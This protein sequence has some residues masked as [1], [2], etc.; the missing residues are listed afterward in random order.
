[1]KKLVA[2][3]GFIVLPLF[4][5]C[6]TGTIKGI[7]KLQLDMSL[8]EVRAIFPKSLQ[9]QNTESKVK[10]IYKINTYTPIKGTTLKGLH[11]YF[12]NDTLYS[13]Y[14]D[15]VPMGLKKDLTLKY[16][17]P[18]KIFP[19]PYY[20]LRYFKNYVEYQVFIYKSDASDFYD[21]KRVNSYGYEGSIYE[22]NRKHPFI[23]VRLAEFTY[24]NNGDLCLDELF[25]IK[26]TAYAKCVEWE[27]EKMKEEKG[28]ERLQEI[29][30][31]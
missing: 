11:L 3:F 8:D 1:M 15:E 29:E 14:I 18:N 31:L 24:Y 7:G 4:C 17:T 12:Y 25:Y 28:Q 23:E 2:L 6:Q 13:I 21:E 9:K 30:G 26:N 5:F 22:W 27:E 19:D 10:K 16:G 20:N